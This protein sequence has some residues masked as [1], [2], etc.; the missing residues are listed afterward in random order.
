MSEVVDKNIE[1]IGKLIFLTQKGKVQWSSEEPSVV[2]G[3]ASDDVISSVFG[4]RYNETQLRI[5]LRRY[6]GDVPRTL[7][8]LPSWAVEVKHS[9]MRWYSEIVLEVV[10]DYGNSI[11]QFPKENILRDLLE[12]VKYKTSDAHG[13]I[14]SLLKEQ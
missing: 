2:R 9:E 1:A 4:C 12:A 5:Y 8:L 11:W 7:G 3:L 10:D 13:V 6:K 14:E